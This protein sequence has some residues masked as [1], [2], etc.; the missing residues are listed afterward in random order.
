MAEL[1]IS[2]F[3]KTMKSMNFDKILR[4]VLGNVLN[5]LRAKFEDFT[6]FISEDLSKNLNFFHF[7]FCILEYPRIDYFTFVKEFLENETKF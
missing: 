1:K 4:W 7:V 6:S 2:K 5:M 3:S